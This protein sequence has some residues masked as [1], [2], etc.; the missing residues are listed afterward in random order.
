M[1]EHQLPQVE[2]G[3]ERSPGGQPGGQDLGLVGLVHTN[4]PNF[5]LYLSCDRTPALACMLVLGGEVA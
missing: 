2:R 3:P 4:T 1:R 5:G